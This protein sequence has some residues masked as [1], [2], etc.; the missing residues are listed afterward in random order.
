MLT[1]TWRDI[2]EIAQRA[3]SP[4]NVQ[5]WKVR[6]ISETDCD[7]YIETARTLPKEDTTGSFI[8]SG[9][10]MYVELLRY[11][12]QIC[13]YDLRYEL[14]LDQSVDDAGLQLFAAVTIRPD[15]TIVP[16]YELE[17]IMR[18]RTS[19]LPYAPE[20]I[21]ATDH[22]SLQ[23]LAQNYG[24]TYGH[25]TDSQLIERILAQNI[26]ALFHD[27]NAPSYH[28]EIVSW[29]RFSNRS[30]I[31]HKDGLDFR[32]MR[33]P[34]TDY[35]LSARFPFILQLPILHTIFAKR[36]RALLGSSPCIAWVSGK[37]WQPEDSVTAGKFLLQFWLELTRMGYYLHPFGNLV[38][39]KPAR[40]AFEA[41]TGSQDVWFV[42]RAGKTA[43]PP[44]SYRRPIEDILI[45]GNS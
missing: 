36:Y 34:A 14:H 5:P 33:V 41:M 24:Q 28:D 45:E 4:H 21:S 31:A 2:L 11:A 42:I 1:K 32:C 18:R 29:F 38:T 3:P 19:R 30:S 12:A 7:V 9:M 40:D 15:S 22:A 44:E 35:Y 13:H 23:V 16:E 27:F 26:S 17:T 37:F 20:P 43:E 8:I 10:V 39:N 25:T 6:I